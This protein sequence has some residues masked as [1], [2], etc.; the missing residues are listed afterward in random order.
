MD[1]KGQNH[2]L[3]PFGS[4]R[5]SCPGVGLALQVM[6]LT[7]ARILQAFEL[8]THPNV[9][10]DLEE[11]SGI[12][13]SMMHPCKITQLSYQISALKRTGLKAM[14]MSLQQ[15]NTPQSI[16]LDMVDTSLA[17]RLDMGKSLCNI[18]S[19]FGIYYFVMDAQEPFTKPKCG[20]QEIT[21][22]IYMQGK[23]RNIHV[24]TD[25]NEIN[26]YMISKTM[27]S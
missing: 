23:P 4:G 19:D 25:R 21:I 12:L 10:V 27:L 20:I 18:C 3:L 6:H 17:K 13:L 26:V 8:K 24:Q 1:V 5:R 15:F 22:T 2:E 11:C 14:E 7:L 16:S 9:G